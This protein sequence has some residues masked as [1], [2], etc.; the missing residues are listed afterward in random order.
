MTAPV[1]VLVVA[2]TPAVAETVTSRL[3][4]LRVNVTLVT[5]FQAARQGLRESTPDLLISEV[6]LG[7][8]NGLHLAL[9]ARSQGVR[10]IMVG[11]NDQVTRREAASL[12]AD[13]LSGDSDPA[14][15][16]AAVQTAAAVAPKRRFGRQRI[17]PA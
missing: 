15:F 11:E 17:H 7:E 1:H 8:F 3:V 14:L 4:D 16:S 10:A 9:R 5:S 6:R 13:Y 12:G 2:P